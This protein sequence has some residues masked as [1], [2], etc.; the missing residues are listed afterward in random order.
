MDNQLGMFPSHSM[1]EFGL[2]INE[3][4][5]YLLQVRRDLTT[6]EWGWFR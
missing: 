4:T 1:A 5:E 3:P 2:D 6:D